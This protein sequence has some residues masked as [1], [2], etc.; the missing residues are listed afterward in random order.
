MNSYLKTLT[1]KDYLKGNNLTQFWRGKF[2]FNTSKKVQCSSRKIRGK[3]VILEAI[4]LFV[5][6][7]RCCK[8]SK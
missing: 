4:C 6:I 2:Y 8:W 1:N 7:Q 3:L 5:L